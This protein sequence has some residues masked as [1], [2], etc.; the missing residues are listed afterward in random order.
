M[1]TKRL[2]GR[3]VLFPAL[4][5]QSMRAV[6]PLARRLL[7]GGERA[8]RGGLLFVAAGKAGAE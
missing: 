1:L 4:R 6:H 3:W 7:R 5:R 8:D 2:T